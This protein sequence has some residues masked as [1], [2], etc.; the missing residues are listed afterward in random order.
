[1]K[2]YEEQKRPKY[3]AIQQQN[4]SLQFILSGII[5]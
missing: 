2:K 5:S 1:M 3:Q 4:G